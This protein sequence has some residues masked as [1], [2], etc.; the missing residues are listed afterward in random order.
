MSYVSK[1]PVLGALVATTLFVVPSVAWGQTSKSS[2]PATSS[3][4]AESVLRVVPNAELVLLDPIWTSIYITR[5]H[6]YLIYDTLFAFDVNGKPRPQMVDTWTES[7]DGLTW[8]F[9]LRDGLKWHDGAAVTAEDCVASLQRWARRSGVGQQLFDVV[10]DISAPDA[11][12]ISIRL[13]TPY[14]YVLESLAELSSVVPFMMPKRVAETDPYT[15]ISEYVGSGPFIFKPDEFVAG[16]KSVYV[17]NTDYVPRSEPP[18]LAAGGKVA[19][20]DRVEWISFPSSE[21]A[22]EALIQNRVDYLESPDPRLISR[23]EK[24][25]D[26][27]IGMTGPDPFVGM[28][29]FNHQAP[30]FDKL[31]VRRAVMMAMDQNDYMKAAL[32]SK[33]YWNTCY[34]VFPCKSLLASEV[35]SDFLKKGSL[36]AA[37]AALKEAGYDGTPVVILDSTDIPVVAAFTKVTADKLRKIG[38]KV[39]V[40]ETDWATMATQR[41]DRNGWSLFHTFWAANDLSDPAKIAFSGDPKTGWFGWPEDKELEMLRRDFVRVENLEVQKAIAEKVQERLW[42]IGASAHLGEFYLPVAYR[43]NVEGVIVSPVQFYW[44]MSVHR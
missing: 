6:G 30:P 27:F 9:T 38:M 42:A 41:A 34:S 3:Q 12:T 20:V 43:T 28:A 8:T 13:K 21:E 14:G 22:I 35:G 2:E 10:D 24:H 16:A 1:H 32:G 23:L 7:K 18:S 4:A 31:E 39:D 40:R 15:P 17:K 5:N 44:N 29:R 36:E 25:K 33:K 19:K 26:I 11:R 37:R